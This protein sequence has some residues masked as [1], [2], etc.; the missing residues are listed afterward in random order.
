MKIKQ[1]KGYNLELNVNWINSLL[2]L[3]YLWVNW[4][5]F[6]SVINIFL[7][8]CQWGEWSQYSKCSMSCGVGTQ[9]RSRSKS[10][11]EMHGG[12][13]EGSSTQTI[14]CNTKECEISE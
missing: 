10:V 7:V 5:L 9:S 12:K 13:C 1:L 11:V 3:F 8:N 2:A 4:I 6:Y 14:P